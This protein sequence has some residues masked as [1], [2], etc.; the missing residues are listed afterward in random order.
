MLNYEKLSDAV[1][2]RIENDKKFGSLPQF[3]FCEGDVIR[4]IPSDKD[5][6]NVW[7]TAFI[8]DIDK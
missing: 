4:R 5:K 3:G 1:T 6:A 7:R 2:L 8:R